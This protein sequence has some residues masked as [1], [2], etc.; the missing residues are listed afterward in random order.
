M[1]GGGLIATLLG[2]KLFGENMDKLI[3]IPL[4]IIRNMFEKDLFAT[5]IVAIL[6]GLYYYYSRKLLK[7]ILMNKRKTCKKCSP[8]IRDEKNECFF[9]ST[10]LG[11]VIKDKQLE[12]PKTVLENMADNYN[13]PGKQY[14]ETQVFIGHAVEFIIL[15]C[16]VIGLFSLTGIFHTDFGQIIN[17]SISQ[18]R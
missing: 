10:F 17:E 11:K 9:C 6:I 15:L 16:L 14:Q 8:G 2:N 7:Q 4:N 1:L 18:A 13:D 3:S 5:I 12:P